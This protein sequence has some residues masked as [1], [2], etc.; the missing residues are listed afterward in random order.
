[1]V[2][3][4]LE[5]KKWNLSEVEE[6]KRLALKVYYEWVRW[7]KNRA[8]HFCI[9]SFYQTDNLARRASKAALLGAILFQSCDF[10]DPKDRQKAERIISIL[11]LPDYLYILKS[12]LTVFSQDKS[13]QRYQSLVGF[14]D[15]IGVKLQ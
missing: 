13:N 1:M 6:C 11:T 8:L 15:D 9:E 5:E 4:F 14:L 2:L 12:Y 10:N 3:F 7:D